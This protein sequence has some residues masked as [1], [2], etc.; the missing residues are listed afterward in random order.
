MASI[1]KQRAL[2]SGVEG[3]Q[4]F[5]CL[6]LP[7]ART[8]QFGEGAN[9][10]TEHVKTAALDLRGELPPRLRKLLDYWHAR[11][12]DRKAPAKV[13]M[14][15]ADFSWALA[16]IMLVEVCPETPERFRYR[17][18]GEGVNSIH[19]HSLKGLSPIDLNPP[20]YGALVEQHY[21]ACCESWQPLAHAISV[22]SDG[23]LGLY[24]RLILPLTDASGER[25]SHLLL[26]ETHEHE[27]RCQ[28]NGYL[29][30]VAANW[31]SVQ[32]GF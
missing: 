19:G 22:K 29:P 14:D 21:R 11:R 15:P 12:G 25:I 23:Q 28:I 26:V 4:K 16:Y 17:I 27:R 24:L 1:L 9:P 31:R 13:E 20:D 5:T 3:G 30:P 7:F 6:S 10:M 8:L 32:P 18:V 2:R